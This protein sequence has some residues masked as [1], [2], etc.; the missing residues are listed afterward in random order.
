[1]VHLTIHRTA[2]NPAEG[3]V[4]MTGKAVHAVDLGKSSG[5]ETASKPID[6]PY[7]KAVP[8]VASGA[9]E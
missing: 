6:L 7:D 5:S 2:F 9:D 4:P 1:M 3:L 8:F